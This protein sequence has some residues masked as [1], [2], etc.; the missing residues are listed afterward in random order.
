M[1]NHYNILSQTIVEKY[2]DRISGSDIKDKIIGEDPSKRVMAGMLAE[3]RIDRDFSGKYVENS[4]TQFESVPSISLSFRIKKDENAKINIKPKGLLFYNVRPNYEETKE[5]VLKSQSEYDNKVYSSIEELIELKPETRISFPLTYKK[6]DLNDFFG[7]GIEVPLSKLCNSDLHLNADIQRVLNALIDGIQNEIR[8]IKNNVISF[9]DL[10]TEDRFNT[11]CTTKD[12]PVDPHWSFD[13][14]CYGKDEG[15]TIRITT[16]LVNKTEIEG[17]RQN[18]YSPRLFDAGIIVSGNDVKFEEFELDYFKYGF[19]ERE[20]IYGVAENATVV[21]DK[22]KNIIQTNNIPVYLQKRLKTKDQYSKYSSFKEL[23]GDPI[24]NLSFILDEMK[25]DYQK[26]IDEYHNSTELNENAKKNYKEAL[27]EY[28]WEIDRFELGIKQIKLKD[29]VYKAFKYTNMSFATNFK[30]AKPITGWRLF[31]VVFIVSMIPVIIR[32]EYKNDEDL[33]E[34]DMQEASLLYFPTGGGKTEAFLG[35]TVFTM[36][37]DRLRGKEDGVSSILKYPLRLLAVQQLDRVLTVIMKANKVLKGIPELSG[38]N[39]FKV[40]FYVGK[41][42]TPNKID[43]KEKL[44]SRGNDSS[45]R[46]LILDSDAETLNEYYRFIDTCPC[47]GKK[48]VRVRFDKD[49]WMLIHECTNPE[50]EETVLPIHIVDNEIYRLMP[51]VVISIIDK[52]ASVGISNDFKMLFGQAKS[53]CSLHGFS[54]TLK[55]SCPNC[56]GTV[57]KIDLLKDPVPS[58]IIQD[59]LHLIKESLGTF[60]SHYESFINYYASS[61][62][63]EEQRK[64]IAFGGNCNNFD[65]LGS[66]QKS[67]SYE[68]KAFSV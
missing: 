62:I 66:H 22:E 25:K 18:G 8:I 23:I 48:S 13:I 34:I 1:S 55:C 52:M 33:R 35:S 57:K 63:P 5:Y 16:Q 2:I 17:G 24:S 26:C 46:N 38:C 29:Y 41:D 60:D 20:P 4:S 58:L 32:S 56:T 28:K 45:S 15:E 9:G 51:S 6:I 43:A 14:Y 36:F 3:N 44:S 10:L 68:S 67:L 61:L 11:V 7:A 53:K 21:F 39:L 50:C 19:K 59:E 47:C 54:S 37:F 30:E 65:V 49:R 12:E 31:Q 42:N 64:K 40:G 27:S